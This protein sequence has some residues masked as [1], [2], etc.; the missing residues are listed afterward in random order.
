[1]DRGIFRS[2]RKD[3][4]VESRNRFALTISISFAVI[5]TLAVS[6][7]V[8]GAPLP[9]HIQS[10][11]LWLIIFF[12]AIGGLSHIF[13]R[14]QDQSTALFLR[15]TISEDSVFIS[16]FIYNQIFLL[17]ILAVVTPLFV[18]L[19]QLEVIHIEYFILSVVAGGV[20]IAAASTI[21]AAIAA[22]AGGKGSLMAVLS[23]PVLLPVLWTSIYAT[24]NSMEA[25]RPLNYDNLFFLLAFSGFISVISFLLFSYVWKED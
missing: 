1:M 25:A 3:L 12:S 7:T 8:G 24:K 13:A 9:S 17:I 21:I 6:L 18:L 19:L 23:F 14:E 10:I 16:K 20:A 15:I 5:I 11:L 4:L 2:L 22:K